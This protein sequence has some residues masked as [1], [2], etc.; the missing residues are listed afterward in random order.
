MQYLVTGA[1]LGSVALDEGAFPLGLETLI[2]G[3]DS[4]LLENGA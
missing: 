1:A 3:L 4:L 2:A